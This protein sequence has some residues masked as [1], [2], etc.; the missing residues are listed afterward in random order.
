MLR[1]QP[2]IRIAPGGAGG[3]ARYRI[4]ALCWSDSGISGGDTDWRLGQTP[5]A[6]NAWMT[7]A[8]L[9]AEDQD[10]REP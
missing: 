9:T 4:V 1:S 6:W 10:V 5:A 8:T 7:L 3:W 2:R